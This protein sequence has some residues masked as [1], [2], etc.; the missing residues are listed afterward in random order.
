MGLVLINHIYSEGTKML[1]NGL[2]IMHVCFIYLIN[3]NY[4]FQKQL[5]SKAMNIRK[6]R[7]HLNYN[8][9]VI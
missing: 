3:A 1:M 8:V 7:I 9:R 6:F 2:I 4:V 5:F